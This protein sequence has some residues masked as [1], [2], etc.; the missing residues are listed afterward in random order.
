[1]FRTLRDLFSL[2]AVA[3]V[4]ARHDALIPREFAGLVPPFARTIGKIARLGARDRGRRPGQRLAAALGG[5][6]PAYVKFGQLLAT[7]PDIIGLQMANDLGELQDKMPPFSM[8]EAEKEIERSFGRPVTALFES[9]SEPVA[10]ASIAQVHKAETLDGRPV[11]VKIL[12]PGIE[13]KARKEFRILLLGARL[14]QRFV[15]AS[16]RLEPVKFISTLMEA[17]EVEFDLR[18]EAGSAS[19]LRENIAEMDDIVIPEVEWQ[20]SSRRVLTV[21]WIDGTALSDPEALAE[22]TINRRHL[23]RRVM[24]VFL[25]TALE[26]G[27]FHADMHQGNL[28]IDAQG[29]LVLI[30]FGI[31]G[32]LDEP[33]RKAFAE[34]IYGFIRRDYKLAAKAHFDAGYVPSHFNMEAFATALRAV[35]EPIFNKR[36]N[37]FDMS[38]V[39]QQL[40]DVTDIFDMHL[41]PELVLLQRTMVVVEGVAR[42]LDP[43]IDLWSTAEPIVKAYVQREIGAAALQRRARAGAEAAVSLLDAFPQFAQAAENVAGQLANGG[44]KLSDDTIE[45][46]ARAMR[47]KPLQDDDKPSSGRKPH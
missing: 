33:A 6:G 23:A 32:R 24:Q 10:A 5:Q 41:R 29:R 21:E 26:Q 20:W 13:K 45:R 39:M 15:P 28:M 47:G 2:F 31:M 35:G 27:F 4:L 14:A 7:R 8:A 46:L 3:W 34:I 43:E 19:E 42:V 37:E 18:I 40:F 11:A 22:R 44:L 36:A 16:R 9:F 1:M 38:G 30:D 12:R 25:T 17:S